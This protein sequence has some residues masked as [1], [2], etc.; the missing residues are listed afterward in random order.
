MPHRRPER[1]V[2]VSDVGLRLIQQQEGFGGQPYVN[3]TGSWAIG[4]GHTY[5]VTEHTP[6]ISEAEAENLLIQDV[7]NSFGP[8][9]A[10]LELPL[11]QNQFDATCSLI[12]QLGVDVLRRSSTFGSYL[13][14]RDWPAAANS[15]LVYDRHDQA[16]VPELSRRRAIER[17]LFLAS[18]ASAPN[19]LD[20]LNRMEREAVDRYNTAL[21]LPSADGAQLEELKARIAVRRRQV[22]VAAIR[23]MEP[24]GA[25]A[26]KGW[27]IELR[28]RRYGVL[29]ELSGWKSQPLAVA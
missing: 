8:A 18:P 25:P 29:A 3:L 20:V 10:S 23:G 26:K 1:D 17:A 13:D 7:A 21:A 12:Y 27:D 15:M 24:D 22:W 14:A 2:N 11:T 6:A 16:V 4:H 19:P 9:I 5:G 28:D